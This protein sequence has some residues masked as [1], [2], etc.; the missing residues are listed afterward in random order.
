LGD[1][2]VPSLPGGFLDVLSY[3][4][5]GGNENGDSTPVTGNISNVP[6]QNLQPASELDSGSISPLPPN[7]ETRGSVAMTKTEDGSGIGVKGKGKEVSFVTP[8][9]SNI[10]RMYVASAAH[11]RSLRDI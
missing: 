7:A 6:I 2:G 8:Q 9:L 1:L 10:S 5:R 4:S 3:F 11:R